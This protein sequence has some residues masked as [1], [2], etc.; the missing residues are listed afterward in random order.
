MKK[1]MK[2]LPAPM[3]L[4]DAELGSV[5]GASGLPY[6]P[7]F[8]W[9]SVGVVQTGSN[10]GLQVALGNAGSTS[11]SMVQGNLNSATIVVG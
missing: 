10:S 3:K 11:Q 8:D 5:A 7:S 4:A 2:T 9:K 6:I 1:T